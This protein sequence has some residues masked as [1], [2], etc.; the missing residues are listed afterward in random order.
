MASGGKVTTIK[1]VP[2]TDGTHTADG[3]GSLTAP[4]PT[5]G[6]AG[7]VHNSVGENPGR[8]DISLDRGAAPSI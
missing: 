8:L 4:F 3:V 6:C 7:V 1:C 2:P 5:T